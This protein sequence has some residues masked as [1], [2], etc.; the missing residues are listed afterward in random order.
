MS[1]VVLERIFVSW[2]EQWDAGTYIASYIRSRRLPATLD[3]R[4]RIE[5]CLSSYPGR[6]PFT[7]SDLDFFLDANLH[8]GQRPS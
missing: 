6:I 2:S 1:A 4:T 5:A 3:E 7:K 8:R